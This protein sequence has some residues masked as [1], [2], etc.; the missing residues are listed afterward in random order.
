MH[1]ALMLG[2]EALIAIAEAVDLANAVME[3]K[4]H[5]QGPDHVV[6]AG[7]KAAAGDDAGAALR[8]VEE[9]LAARAGGLEG[10]QLLDRNAAFDG[11]A[12][13]PSNSTRSVSSTLWKLLAPLA[14]QL[15]QRRIDATRPQVFYTQ[16]VCCNCNYHDR[17]SLGG[18]EFHASFN[19]AAKEV[20]C[21]SVLFGRITPVVRMPAA[22]P[23]T[24]SRNRSEH[25]CICSAGASANSI[26]R[27][28]QSI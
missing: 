12:A 23:C 1:V 16:V 22:I 19:D 26:R 25:S 6:H 11:R 10:R 3:V 28:S 27:L 14:K 9:D 21:E 13:V 15:L 7:A 8:G 24:V 18:T 2:D 4:L 17:T 20:F 5:D